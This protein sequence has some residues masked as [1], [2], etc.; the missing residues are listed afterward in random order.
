MVCRPPSPES[1]AQGEDLQ[2]GLPLDMR[3]PQVLS[4]HATT[5]GSGVVGCGER[6]EKR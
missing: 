5:N 4:S 1:S 2:S 3:S 6:G